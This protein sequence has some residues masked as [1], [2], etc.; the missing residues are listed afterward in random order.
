[1]RNPKS[2][3]NDSRMPPFPAN[4]IGDA[5]LKALAEYLASLK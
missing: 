2:K 5:D 1:V 3:K 4:K